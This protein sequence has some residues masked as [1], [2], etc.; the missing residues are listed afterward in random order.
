MN[1]KAL[2]LERKHELSLRDIDLPLA[3]GPTDVRIRIDTVGVCGSDVHITP[4]AASAL[5]SSRRR[6]CW[7]TR[8][9]A[10]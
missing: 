4:T 10:R 5:S 3:V 8:P 1:M 7:A 2:V 9:P 6:W